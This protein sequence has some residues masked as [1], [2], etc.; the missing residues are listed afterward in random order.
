MTPAEFAELK[1]GDKVRA[2]S[3]FILEEGEIVF[4]TPE[5]VVV[6]WP[7]FPHAGNGGKMILPYE[8][9][10]AFRDLLN[11]AIEHQKT[12]PPDYK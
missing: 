7:N 6:N 5:L 2:Q 9:M 3:D 11:D 10:V 1:I 12:R 4:V 8:F